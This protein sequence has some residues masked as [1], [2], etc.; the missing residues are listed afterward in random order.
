MAFREVLI[1]RIKE[2]KD[3]DE[4]KQCLLDTLAAYPG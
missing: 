3:L 1:L 4:V 2:A